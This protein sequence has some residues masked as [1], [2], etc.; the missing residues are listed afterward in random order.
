MS[1]ENKTNEP[2]GGA[3]V[4]KR[5]FFSR[6]GAFF[7][8]LSHKEC[9]YLLG[10]FFIP[11]FIMFAAHAAVGFYPFG[12]SSVLS[13]DFQAQ[14]VYYFTELR[15]TLTEGGGWFY[16]W[17][18]TLGGEFMGYI[19]YYLGS[20][21]NLFVL[22]FPE[23]HVAMACAF[24]ILVKCGSMGV[25]MGYYLH[26]TRGTRG[27]RTLIFSTLYAL[28]GYVGVQQF[29]PMW[30]DALIWLPL[31]VLGVERLVKERKIILY[32]VSLFLILTSNYYIGYMCCI[33]TVIYFIHYYIYV[34][35]E[36]VSEAGDEKGRG[37][38]FKA[39]FARAFFRIAGA[40]VV[41]GLMSAFMLLA[42]YYSLSFGKAGF[43][44]P[45]YAFEFNFDFLD[46]F[47]KMLIGSY[48]TVRPNGF[49]IVYS[50][51]LGLLLLPA[52]YMSKG[53]SPRRKTIAS[54]LLVIIFISF[55]L[56]PVDLVWHGFS[57]PNWLNYRYS[58]IFSFLVITMACDAFMTFEQVKFGHFAAS[59]AI[60]LALTAVVQKFNYEF[61]QNSKAL[62]L[63]DI[64]VIGLSVM[65]ILMYIA[66]AYA[67]VKFKDKKL[68]T[69]VLLAVVV[70]E[71]L[72]N[73]I[74]STAR[75]E[76]DVGVVKYNNYRAS[77]GSEVERY[78]SHSGSVERMATIY[79]EIEKN[80]A[81]LF[82]TESTIYRQ[83]G[84]VNEQMG[85]GFNGI[86]SSTSTLNK[87]IITFMNKMGYASRSHWTKYL[88]GTPISDALFGIKYVISSDRPNEG[89]G[90]RIA[91]NNIHSFDSEIYVKSYT[92]AEPS[93]IYPSSYSVY[94]YQ[95]TKALSF[96][97]GVSRNLEGFDMSAKGDHL[98]APDF[99]NRIIN[100]MLSE[101]L[102]NVNVMRPLTMK[103]ST[104]NATVTVGSIGA[105]ENNVDYKAQAYTV[106][107]TTTDGTSSVT[108]TTKA[109]IDGVVYFH[110]T[111][112]N[113]GK[114]ANLYLNGKQ[115]YVGASY[116]YYFESNGVGGENSTVLDLGYFN[117]GDEIALE[118]R[119]ADDK[120]WM[121]CDSESYFWYVDY[122]AM[123]E[124]FTALEDASLFVE[125]YSNQ[126]IKGTINLPKGQE[127][128]FTSIPYDSG[129]HA[130]VDGKEV[131]TTE[132]L[133]SMLA[134]ET[135]AG[136]HEIT[137]RYFPTAYKLG[138]ALT[139]I[140]FSAFAVVVLY[141]V[142]DKFRENIKR[143]A[144]K[145]YMSEKK[146]STK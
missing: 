34:R 65:F 61:Q 4:K 104:K 42:A 124:A 143:V 46:I 10:A 77:D 129:W 110:A 93:S 131:K 79:D 5:D 60:M 108:F 47:M 17:S 92:A 66:I 33:F 11:F 134:F 140:G 117:A 130:Y 141:N 31:L 80:D 16:T 70:I 127:L 74:I 12:N 116:N 113:F 94:G 58:F 27:F 20:P 22:F 142:S 100:T 64:L 45:S 95:N 128:V 48:D 32:I 107:K 126:Y 122:N 56:N 67:L 52:F 119:L 84:G 1:T 85:V 44:N 121:I 37:R 19:A 71:L 144:G 39:P 90:G 138:I 139:V 35:P 15:R 38:F 76:E 9:F 115:L 136:F 54:S 73:A 29:N 69:F 120:L 102:G 59:S 111:T 97:Y 75:V 30:L 145:I 55:L 133:E 96:A 8:G 62:A 82:R 88:G 137:L 101:T 2:V 114:T 118:V 57:A 63:D 14:Y 81:G 135:T 87:K 99:Q 83:R 51:M 6:V 3:S 40:T 41:A 23:K 146:K 98:V 123:N 125:E 28:C 112:G 91:Q 7:A 43:S 24:I 50:G 89:N 21:F 25:T 26:K 18:R 109:L 68:T 86:S 72:G 36:L 132:V 53:V 78:D 105:K 13:L 103:Y 106:T 49:P